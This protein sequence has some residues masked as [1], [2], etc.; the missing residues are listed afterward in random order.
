MHGL[1]QWSAFTTILAE[2]I[3]NLI[4]VYLDAVFYPRI[5]PQIFQQEGW[6]FEIDR[7]DG[8][9]IYKGVVYNEMKGAM[10]SADQVMARAL[11][12]AM[13]PDTTYSNNS[14]GDPAV[15]PTLTYQQ[16]K[17]FH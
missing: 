2:R 15:I 6:H 11:L 8:P 4:D 10:S 17:A 5:T 16:L 7:P 14:G 3:Y 9:M 12:N 13:Y 1:P